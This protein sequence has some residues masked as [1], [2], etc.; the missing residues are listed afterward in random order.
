MSVE[1][2]FDCVPELFMPLSMQLSAAESLT[3]DII[4]SETALS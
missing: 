2:T 3:E 1:L 4:L